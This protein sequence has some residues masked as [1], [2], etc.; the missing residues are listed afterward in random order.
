[1]MQSQS[2]SGMWQRLAPESSRVSS[3][4][5]LV[6]LPG[7]RSR[8]ALDSGVQLVLWGNLPQQL[9][10][11]LFE[12]AVVLHAPQAPE[13]GGAPDLDFTL[14]R[15]RVWLS[16]HKTDKPAYVRARFRKEVWDLTLDPGTE[17]A[18]DLVGRESGWKAERV[19][20][21]PIASALLIVRHGRAQ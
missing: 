8:I 11:P 18:L 17:L 3:T 9:D 14:L 19:E 15:G 16:N 7:Y 21:G 5:T 12:S 1:L 20:E 13:G 10:I 4:D 2:G 6:S